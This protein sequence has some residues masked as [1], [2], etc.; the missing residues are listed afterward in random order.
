MQTLLEYL[1][2]ENEAYF[3]RMVLRCVFK[4]YDSLFK[5]GFTYKWCVLV[6]KLTQKKNSQNNRHT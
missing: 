5:I 4:L 6:M 1:E 2:S 3:F